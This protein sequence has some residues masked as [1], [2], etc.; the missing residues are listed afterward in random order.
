VPV[1]SVQDRIEAGGDVICIIEV[2]GALKIRKMFPD[3]LLVFLKPP[4]GKEDEI[5]RQRIQQRG[6][7]NDDQIA[8]RMETA[9]WELGQTEFYD[10]Q[11]VNDEIDFAAQQLCDIIREEKQSRSDG[12]RASQTP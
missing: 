8:R 2:Q 3:S 11:I 9:A 4:P 5:L 6:A 12:S 1:S 7:E 10:Y